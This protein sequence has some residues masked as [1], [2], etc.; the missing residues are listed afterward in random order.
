MTKLTCPVC[1]TEV[2]GEGKSLTHRWR[3]HS[4][5][6]YYCPTCQL[7][8]WD[9]REMPGEQFY[10][11]EAE[12]VSAP[13]LVRHTIGSRRLGENHLAFFQR[14]PTGQGSLLD[15]GCGDGHFLQEAQRRGFQV[16]GLDFDSK[17]LEVAAKRGVADLYCTSL[18]AFVEEAQQQ[19]RRY[20]WVTFFEVL[21]HQAEPLAFMQMVAGLLK[22]GGMIA[23]SVP[24]RNRFRLAAYEN[25]DRPPYHFTRWSEA[26]AVNLLQ[27]AGLDSV[28]A[29]D[30]GHGYYLLARFNSANRSVKKALVKDVDD[31]T[32]NMYTM[33]EVAR[34]TQVSTARLASLK[35]L[36]RAKALAF[37]P[38]IAAESSVGY[39]LD[40]G[41]FLYFEGRLPA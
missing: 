2:P 3:S 10:E 40:K 8:F 29:E 21:E 37:A 18:E 1:A 14:H 19:G 34:Q 26:S 15:I 12:E 38:V 16:G 17:A 39:T 32:L 6:L 41:Q 20:D 31:R 9:P 7:G 27:R 23:G 11:T 36:K 13:V 4:F 25:S 22:P 28:F 35:A 30:V 5:S 24:N 33:E